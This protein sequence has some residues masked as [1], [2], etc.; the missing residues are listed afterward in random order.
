MGNWGSLVS[1]VTRLWAEKVGFSC[2]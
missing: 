1:I 2:W